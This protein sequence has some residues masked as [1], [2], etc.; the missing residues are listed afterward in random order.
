[1]SSRY[2]FHNPKGIYFITFSVKEWVDV[3]TRNIYKDI[4]TESLEYC[5]KNKGL[6]LYAWCI[7]SNHVH[8][9]IGAKEGFLLQNIMR[10][11][12]RHTSKT[13]VETIKDNIQESRKKWLLKHFLT[14]DGI[15]F[16]QEGN[17][18]IEIWSNKI[19]NQKLNYLHNNPVKAGIV[20]RPEQYVYSSAVD[21]AGG[22]G[23]L[24]IIII[25]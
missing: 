2:K 1:M 4:L 14:T 12:K 24:D 11:F 18:P 22:K 8:L 17:H 16:W 20:F 9:I 6:D 21:Y 23:L 10:D 3:F 13:V 25:Q 7:M 15:S 19:I 5:Q